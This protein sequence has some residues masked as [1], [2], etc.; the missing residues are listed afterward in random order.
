MAGK[1]A[2][3]TKSPLLYFTIAL[4]SLFLLFIIFSFRNPNQFNEPNSIPNPNYMPQTSFVASLDHF[5]LTHKAP[6]LPT[7]AKISVKELDDLVW[8]SESRKL[9]G[10]PYY[11]I[12][13]PIRVYVYE[14]PRK[15]TYDLLWLFRDTYRKTSN[16]TSNGSPVH[17]LIEQ[18]FFSPFFLKKKNIFTNFIQVL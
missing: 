17:R 12:N 3:R 4:V 8:K 5:L 7:V 6:P 1:Q 18:V 2:P 10:E 13:M 16:L 14:M 9:Y 15:F 11:P